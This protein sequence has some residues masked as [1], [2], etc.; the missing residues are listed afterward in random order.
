MPVMSNSKWARM[1]VIG[2]W[3]VLSGT[4]L[5]GTYV[6]AQ[7][8]GGYRWIQHTGQGG[9]VAMLVVMSLLCLA[10]ALAVLVLGRL[11]KLMTVAVYT[12]A[13]LH[14][15][16][17]TGL[18]MLGNHDATPTSVLLIYMIVGSLTPTSTAFAGMPPGNWGLFVLPV[19]TMLLCSISTLTESLMR[20]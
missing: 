6:I 12:T 18:Y 19:S 20:R 8:I 14:L 15:F 16:N 5:S 9:V 13:G 7:L 1:S 11:P 2:L 10:S 17:A 3:G 4:W